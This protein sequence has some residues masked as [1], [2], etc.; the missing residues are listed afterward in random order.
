MTLPN[1]LTFLLGSLTVTLTVLLFLIH[2]IPIS[3]R[4][5]ISYVMKRGYPVVSLIESQWKL[6]Q[7]QN[8]NFPNG[9]KAIVEQTLAS[10]E[11]NKSKRAGL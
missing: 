3:T 5:V 11:I 10:K 6:T 8:Q 2:L 9:G 1:W 7:Q 4:I